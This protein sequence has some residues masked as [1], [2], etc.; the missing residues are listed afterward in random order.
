MNHRSKLHREAPSPRPP[1]RDH[2]DMTRLV[3]TLRDLPPE[4]VQAFREELH[5]MLQEETT[6]R[7]LTPEEA[8]ARLAVSPRTLREWIRQKKIRGVRVA[9]KLLRVPESALAEVLGPVDVP[10][11]AAALSRKR[12]KGEKT[13]GSIPFGYDV[14]PGPDGTRCLVANAQEQATVAL[15]C[16]LGTRAIACGRSPPSSTGKGWPRK[17]AA[18]GRRSPSPTC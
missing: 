17:P 4:R 13:G 2:L 3:Q 12:E 15:M 5:T 9:G 14:Q 1:L 8:A 18:A 7:L 16:H 6:E 11:K 10:A